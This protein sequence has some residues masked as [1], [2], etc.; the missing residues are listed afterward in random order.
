MPHGEA[1]RHTEREMFV[2]MKDVAEKAKTEEEKAKKKAAE[3]AKKELEETKKKAAE[4]AKGKTKGKPEP[5]LVYTAHIMNRDGA[6]KDKWQTI[7]R[8]L[9]MGSDV[10]VSK[11]SFAAQLAQ[12]PEDKLPRTNQVVSVRFTDYT[13]STTSTT[14]TTGAT[15]AIGGATVKATVNGGKSKGGN[16]VGTGGDVGGE[17]GEGG[18]AAGGGG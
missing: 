8:F 16:D 2:Y 11:A 13:A 18:G 3:K 17:L 15:G 1:V 4:K 7:P 12:T 9:G 14:S 10:P 5:R 6:A